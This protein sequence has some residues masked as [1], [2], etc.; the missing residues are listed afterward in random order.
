[1]DSALQVNKTVKEAVTLLETAGVYR[2]HLRGKR[3]K[4]L[5]RQV[6]S[7]TFREFS[8]TNTKSLESKF[9]KKKK[10]NV[11]VVDFRNQKLL[12]ILDKIVESVEEY[13]SQGRTI[14]DQRSRKTNNTAVYKKVC[15]RLYVLKKTQILQG[16]Q[17]EIKHKICVS[18]TSVINM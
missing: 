17:Q 10:I 18:L 14:D 1:M 13:K 16:V 6:M 8:N 2:L 9:L 7:L 12:R 11:I 5:Y 3:S 15:S 4:L